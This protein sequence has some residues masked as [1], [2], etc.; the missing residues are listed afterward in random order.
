MNGVGSGVFPLD[1]VTGALAAAE[2]VGFTV[3]IRRAA[4][5]EARL[6]ST[7]QNGP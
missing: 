2:N 6:G 5:S 3:L 4:S 7:P 1:A